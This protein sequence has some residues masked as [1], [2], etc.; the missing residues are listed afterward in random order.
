MSKRKYTREFK[1]AAVRMVN[2]EGYTPA[3]AGRSLGIEPQN[4]RNWVEALGPSVGRAPGDEPSRMRAELRRLRE[5]NKHPRMEGEILERAAAYF[6][7][8]PTW[9]SRSSSTI[10][11]S[12][13]WN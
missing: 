8:R 3:E 7:S 12:I 13:P 5:E 4:V 11:R 1:L 10:A 6:A 2:H 9:G